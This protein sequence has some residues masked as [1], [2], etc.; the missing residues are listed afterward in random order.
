MNV[1]DRN[2]SGMNPNGSDY[3]TYSMIIWDASDSSYSNSNELPKGTKDIGT[4][5]KANI[6][7]VTPKNDKIYWGTENGRYSKERATDIVASAKT[8]HSSFFIYGFGAMWMKDPSK[9]VM[10]ELEKGARKGYK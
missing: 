4:N 1:T 6:Y 5:D 3:T 8:M 7:L 2:I 9:F 10:I